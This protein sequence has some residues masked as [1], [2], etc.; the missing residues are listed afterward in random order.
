MGGGSLWNASATAIPCTA[1]APPR[2]ESTCHFGAGL[3]KS[4]PGPL[5]FMVN[6]GCPVPADGTPAADWLLISNA[7]L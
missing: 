7:I 4:G 1:K 6:Y 5:S 2:A 3:N